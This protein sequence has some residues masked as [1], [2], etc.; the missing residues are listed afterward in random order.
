MTPKQ[1]PNSL[2]HPQNDPRKFPEKL[3]EQ[4]IHRV[5]CTCFQQLNGILRF[6]NDFL[7]FSY[8]HE[9]SLYGC[10]RQYCFLIIIYVFFCEFLIFV[11]FSANA[12]F[13]TP[14]SMNSLFSEFFRK[15]GGVFWG[16]FEIIWGHIRGVFWRCFRRFLEGFRG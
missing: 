6:L 12:I 13:S 15:F 16:V 2:A 7:W 11:R 9:D 4:T 10:L 8:E 3:A 14:Y 5:G 1:S